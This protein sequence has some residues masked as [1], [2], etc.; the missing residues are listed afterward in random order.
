MTEANRVVEP[1]TPVRGSRSGVPLMA[2]LDLLGRRWT[3]T[4][5]WALR[6][7]PL[8]SRQ[9]RAACDDASPSVIQQRLHELRAAD[10]VALR[11]GGGYVLTEEGQA[12][13]SCIDPLR[14]W[15]NRWAERLGRPAVA[16]GER[17]QRT[18]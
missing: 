2:A 1:G 10:V 11:E 8:T 5:V 13:R 15:A 9:I 16:A 6:D 4:I 18:E 14:D 12:L 17:P 7:G 3:L